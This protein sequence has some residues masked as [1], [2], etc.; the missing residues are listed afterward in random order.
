MTSGRV[1]EQEAAER[2]KRSKREKE[3]EKVEV[4]ENVDF[5]QNSSSSSSLVL[6]TSQR[7]SLAR[8]PSLLSLTLSASSKGRPL[9]LTMVRFVQRET[10]EP[11]GE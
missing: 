10:E 4:D 7:S 11:P 3:V 8:A 5:A 2:D 6:S 1:G 9:A